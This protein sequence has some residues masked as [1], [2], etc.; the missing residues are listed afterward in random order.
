MWRTRLLRTGP[1][2]IAGKI[3]A[4][5]DSVSHGMTSKTIIFLEGEDRQKASG[6]MSTGWPEQLG[7]F[8]DDGEYSQV[9]TVV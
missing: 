8:L 3:A 2:S 4:V 5:Q 1:R 9:E 7:T 6:K